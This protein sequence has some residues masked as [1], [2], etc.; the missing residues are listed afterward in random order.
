MGIFD[1]FKTKDQKDK[2]EESK[3]D[4]VEIEVVKKSEVK[5]Y[6][7]TTKITSLLLL[8]G[9]GLGLLSIFS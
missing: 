3:K 8:F 2:K 4:Q 5:P 7:E 1:R 6:I 9:C